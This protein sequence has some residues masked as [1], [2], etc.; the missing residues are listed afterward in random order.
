MTKHEE[1]IICPECEKEQVA[2]VEHT[3]PFYS[4]VHK[5]ANI[6]CNYIITE[7]DWNV[8]QEEIKP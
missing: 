2:E 5:C 7:S 4:Y 6:D 8:K 1:I 3:F